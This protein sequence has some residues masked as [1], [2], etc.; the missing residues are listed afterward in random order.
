MRRVGRGVARCPDESDYISLLHGESFFDVRR[1][2][3]QMSIVVHV[4]ATG[5]GDVNGD[6]A[7]SAVG[8]LYDSSVGS[9]KY[10]RAAH[11][12]DIRRH[13]DPP[14]AARLMIGIGQLARLDTLD[15]HHQRVRSKVGRIRRQHW[16]PVQ[17]HRAFNI[18]CADDTGPRSSRPG[19]CWLAQAH[20]GSGTDHTAKERR[21]HP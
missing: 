17:W 16:A 14:T 9:G 20:A 11:R 12:H 13:M 8:E 2:S 5:V 15:R 18:D 21:A 10:R 3:H 1:V 4:S 6:A 19:I 7:R